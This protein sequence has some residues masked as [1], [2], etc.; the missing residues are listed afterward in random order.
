MNTNVPLTKGY[1]RLQIWIRLLD[2]KPELEELRIAL[3][4]IADG[5]DAK[6]ALGLK[7]SRGNNAKKTHESFKK[8]FAVVWVASAMREFGI[9]RSEAIERAANHFG[10]DDEAMA[11]YAQRLDEKLAPDGSFDYWELFPKG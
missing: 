8:D 11:R 6:T 2:G 4:Q 3:E 10:I 5:T 7:L 1:K 9:S